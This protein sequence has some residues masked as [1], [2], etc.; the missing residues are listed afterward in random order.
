MQFWQPNRGLLGV[1]GNAVVPRGLLY[2][3]G[4]TW[5]QLSTV[6]GGS[7]DTMRI[8]WAGPTEFWTVSAPSKPRIGDGITL[9]RFKDGEVVGSFGAPPS[10]GDPY[11]PMNSATCNG[12]ADCWFGGVS[13]QDPS[14]ARVGAFRLHW[15]GAGLRTVYGPQGRA[16][17]DMQAF[18]GAIFE[19]VL[20]GPQAGR[21]EAPVL[22][23]AEG[24]PRLIHRLL[25]GR[26]RSDPFVP[27]ERD[28][29]P[30]DGSELLALDAA[31]G[32]LW[33]SGGGAA[34]G[35]SA[36]EDGAVDRPPLVARYDGTRFRELELT[37]PPG[38]F[39][40]GDRFADLAVLPGRNAAWAT[41]QPY[42]R[43]RSTNA[44]G[45]VARIDGS[46]GAVQVERIPSSGSGRGSA[47]RIECVGPEEC[48]A[49]TYGGWLFHLTDGRSHPQDDEPAFR[50]LITFRPNE[51]AA[52][53]V[54]DTPP[55][56]DSSLFAAPPLEIEA[57]A[58]PAPA[59]TRRLPALMRRV[60]TRLRGTR[61]VVTFTLQRPARVQLLALRRGKRVARTKLR[62]LKP[63]RRR[64]TL[65]LD[66][67]R[68][69][70]R[71]RFVLREA[72]QTGSEAD[73]EAGA[74]DTVTTGG[75][76]APSG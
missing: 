6:C 3:D 9:C 23:E 51:S 42:G 18:N 58:A 36:P 34:S 44:E 39:G 71:L 7:T 26:F 70:T 12:P 22:G 14:G 56:D 19:S 37:A 35:P 53:F 45:A 40:P 20:V 29:V 31:N 54:P 72:G 46:T 73:G 28:G 13:A 24:A 62:A 48:W 25:G 16:I 69:P 21:R 15:D 59:E 30:V 1:E 60:R 55:V 74:G 76:A 75:G 4:R 43:R 38:T 5:K 41:V 57:E 11:F 64:V 10:S 52:Q 27:A 49:A 65:K 47:A 61:L 33:A 32:R 17:S 63:G 8:A 66:R 67:K 68:W 2:Y 50:S